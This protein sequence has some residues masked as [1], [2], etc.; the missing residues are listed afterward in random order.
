MRC[1]VLF[2]W[3][4]VDRPSVLDEVIIKEVLDD[5]R[6]LPGAIVWRVDRDVL[7]RSAGARGWV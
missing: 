3:E 4:S 2:L 1:Y 6:Y 5:V 7:T